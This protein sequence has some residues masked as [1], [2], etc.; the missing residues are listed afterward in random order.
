MHG[1]DNRSS[2]LNKHSS[3]FRRLVLT[4]QLVEQ[5]YFL[6]AAVYFSCS[7]TK[8]CLDIPSASS[9]K[10]RSSWPIIIAVFV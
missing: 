10:P 9:V 1:L 8:S 5:S 3:I 7:Y 6:R 2:L 4:L